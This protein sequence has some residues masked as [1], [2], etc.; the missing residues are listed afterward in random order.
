MWDRLL[1]GRGLAALEHAE[2]LGGGAYTLHAAIAACHARAPSV[3]ETDWRRVAAL[4]TVL[5]HLAP[6]SVVFLN[7][8]VALGMAEGP[9]HGLKVL[10]PLTDDPAMVGYP[11][12]PAARATF[13][14]RLGRTEEARHEFAR[15]ASLTQNASERRLYLRQA[16]KPGN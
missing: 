9:R 6:S 13:L 14:Q 8:A 10:D 4:Y 12:L 11:Q 15:A 5:A 2:D 3:D 7:R 1:I 16:A